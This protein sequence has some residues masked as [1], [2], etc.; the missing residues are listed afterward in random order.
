MS[1]DDNLDVYKYF[2]AAEKFV[3]NYLNFEAISY[4]ECRYKGSSFHYFKNYSTTN[5]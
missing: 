5:N 3:R 1:V 4:V 2:N